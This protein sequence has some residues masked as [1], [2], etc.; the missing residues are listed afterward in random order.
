[1]FRLAMIYSPGLRRV[2]SSPPQ[3]D[4]RAVPGLVLIRLAPSC[5]EK[6]EVVH[7]QID[8]ASHRA[9]RSRERD[10]LRKSRWSIMD[11]RCRPSSATMNGTRCAISPAT[12]AICE[13]A[14]LV[15]T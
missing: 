1:M 6:A 11:R 10:A 4:G 7:D 2:T 3:A 9:A 13:K 8:T 12:N 14:D 5:A 15:W